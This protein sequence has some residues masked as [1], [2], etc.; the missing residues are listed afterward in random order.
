TGVLRVDTVQELFDV[1]ASLA[2]QPVPRGNRVAVVTNAGGPGILATDAL[3]NSGLEMPQLSKA[4]VRE[5]KKFISEDASFSNPM[6][7]VAGAGPEEYRKTLEAIERDKKFDSIMS[8]FV[9]PVMIDQLEVARNIQ[10]AVA[11]TKKTVLACFMG[12][13]EGSTGVDHLKQHGIPVY[14]FP[15]AIAKTLAHLH[16][17]RKWLKRKPGHVRNFKVDSARVSQ[18]VADSLD[19]RSGAIVGDD[20]LEI[21]KAYGIQVAGYQYAHSE[22]EA[23]TVAHRLKYPVVMKM[24]SP[25]LLHKTEKGGVMVDLRSDTEVRR[26]FRQLRQRADDAEPVDKFSVAMQQMITGAVE[27]V[28]GMTTDPSFG[29]LMMFG[30]G[31]IYVEV[32]KDVAFRI[33][34]LTDQ[35]AKEMIQSLRSYP[36]LTGFRGAEPVDLA[37]VEDSLLRLSQLVRDFDCFSEIDINPFIVSP[38][39]ENCRAVDARFIIGTTT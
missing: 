38:N 25:T 17:Y 37:T 13:G 16:G 8:I 9:P 7:M 34:P 11:K 32:M 12:A 18:I 5:L 6:D 29:P 21:L 35:G 31:G 39:K 28:I 36:L 20:A 27:T 14:Q 23:I 30:L 22:K 2:A 15:E 26:A 24:A 1:A 4:T 33:N 19:G 10:I 3:I